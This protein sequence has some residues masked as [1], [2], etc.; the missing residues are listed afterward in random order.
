MAIKQQ[1]LEGPKNC[2][3]YLK[4]FVTCPEKSFGCNL[5]LQYFF[6]LSTLEK[7]LV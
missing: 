5:D 6:Q 7:L 2:I 3:I 1:S 4:N